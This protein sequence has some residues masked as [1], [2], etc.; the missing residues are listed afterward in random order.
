MV[1]IAQ[2]KIRLEQKLSELTERAKEIDDELSA[3]GD[4]DW[5]EA[6]TESAGDESL[7]E[8]GDV[9]LE[10]IAQIREALARIEAGRYGFCTDCGEE[11]AEARLQALPNATKCMDCA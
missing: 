5:K 4:D 7:E 9:T 8:V 2:I 10:E 11:I 6:A 3:P 1:D